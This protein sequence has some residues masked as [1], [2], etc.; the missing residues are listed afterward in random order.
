MAKKSM[1]A[2]DVKRKRLVERYSAKRK[3]LLNQFIKQ[4][5]QII[6]TAIS[7]DLPII[8]LLENH[9]YFEKYTDKLTKFNL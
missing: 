5:H 8:K 4:D 1:I 9:K 7:E 3:K 2:R 6:L